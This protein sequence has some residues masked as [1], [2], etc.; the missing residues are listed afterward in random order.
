MGRGKSRDRGTLVKISIGKIVDK[1]IDGDGDYLVI[2]KLEDT[3]EYNRYFVEAEQYYEVFAVG[4]R[5]RIT[6]SGF[7]SNNL[8]EKIQ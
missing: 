6:D 1:I 4:D 3:G 2:V 7:F 8:Y 5:I